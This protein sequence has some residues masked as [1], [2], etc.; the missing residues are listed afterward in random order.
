MGWRRYIAALALAPFLAAGAPSGA[1]VT[2]ADPASL[3]ERIDLT[4]ISVLQADYGRAVQQR[5]LPD[6][7]AYEGEIVA[8]LRDEILAHAVGEGAP[9]GAGQGGTGA[10]TAASGRA[11]AATPAVAVDEEEVGA[12]ALDAKVADLAR[13]FISLAGRTDGPS[14]TRKAS[15]LG[16][17]Q[18]TSEQAQF[19]GPAPDRERSREARQRVDQERREREAAEQLR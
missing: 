3:A 9:R 4:R 14:L 1:P 12:G 15:I 7:A 17:L 19:P 2:P 16:A 8:M 10:G 18:R 5:D 13:E 6:V 11:A